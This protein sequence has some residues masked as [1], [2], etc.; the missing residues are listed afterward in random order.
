MNC[1]DLFRCAFPSVVIVVAAGCSTRSETFI[2]K[3]NVQE[4]V[5]DKTR[6]PADQHEV[7]PRT[8]Y[9]LAS[10]TGDSAGAV[11]TAEVSGALGPGSSLACIEATGGGGCRI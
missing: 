10:A 2:H 3:V 7:V 5:K 6:V 4:L 1:R 9:E 8:Y 11:T